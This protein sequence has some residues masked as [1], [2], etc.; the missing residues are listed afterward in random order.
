MNTP[1]I[2]A[3]SQQYAYALTGRNDL[4]G[5][6]NL[7][8]P[9]GYNRIAVAYLAYPAWGWPATF[10]LLNGVQGHLVGHMT[11]VCQGFMPSEVDIYIWY[12]SE[13]PASAGTYSFSAQSSAWGKWLM[14][15]GVE[16]WGVNQELPYANLVS[17]TNRSI[18]VDVVPGVLVIDGYLQD[19]MSPLACST[20]DGQT[21]IVNSGTGFYYHILGLSAKY[22]IATETSENMLWTTGAAEAHMALYFGPHPRILGPLGQNN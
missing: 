15:A 21:F 13:L 16:L 14:M 3:K 9:S 5:V 6:Y 1:G 4:T 11:G 22:S 8:H 18:D 12:D 7:G 2:G 17:N 10:C 20:V 19:E